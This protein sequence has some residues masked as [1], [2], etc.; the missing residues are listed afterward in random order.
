MVLKEPDPLDVRSQED[1]DARVPADRMVYYLRNHFRRSA[2]VDVLHGLRLRCGHSVARI[3]HLLLHA[4]GIVVVQRS[5]AV[6]QL[7]VNSDGQWSRLEA[8]E[9]A[10]LSSPVTHAYIQALLLKDFLDR[11]VR[12]R[13]F[14]DQLGLDVLVVLHDGCAVRWPPEGAMEEVCRREEV[15]DRVCACIM[16]SLERQSAEYYLGPSERRTLGRFLNRSH[17][18]LA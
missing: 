13:G 3:D 8:P 1:L 14:F 17:Q 18:P 12:Q 10:V 4:H 2:E 11:H 9:P 7:Q 6:G 15:F 16:R 5:D